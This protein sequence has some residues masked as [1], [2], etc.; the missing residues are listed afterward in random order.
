MSL[1]RTY[2]IKKRLLSCKLTND[3][4]SLCHW[5][6]QDCEGTA[7]VPWEVIYNQDR[8]I[9]QY[10]YNYVH[11]HTD[12]NYIVF[13]IKGYSNYNKVVKYHA[14]HLCIK[15]LTF[16]LRCASLCRILE[17]SIGCH[18]V[19]ANMFFCDTNSAK[20]HQSAFTYILL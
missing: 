15:F 18:Y 9:S 1:N 13:T 11:N 16:C 5:G 14:V 7:G 17:F 3:C 12:Y 20:Q 6:L 8:K 10:L 19:W 4:Q 2:S